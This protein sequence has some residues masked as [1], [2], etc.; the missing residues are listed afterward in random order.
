[1]LT[2]Y[3][4]RVEADVQWIW[5]LRFIRGKYLDFIRHGNIRA[6]IIEGGTY[7]RE[8]LWHM[9]KRKLEFVPLELQDTRRLE[10][11]ALKEA[12]DNCRIRRDEIDLTLKM[13]EAM[14]ASDL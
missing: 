3:E 9:K 12:I 10:K 8:L 1:M 7:L 6:A 14:K 4:K 13:I 5:E 11:E 2:E